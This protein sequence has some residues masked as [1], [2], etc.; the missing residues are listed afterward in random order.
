MK[1]H[2]ETPKEIFWMWTYIALTCSIVI[3]VVAL[4]SELLIRLGVN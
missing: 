4:V 1:L 2:P 3:I